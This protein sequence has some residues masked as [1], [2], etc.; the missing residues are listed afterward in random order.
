MIGLFLQVRVGQHTKLFKILKIRTYNEIGQCSKFGGF[1]RK[2]KLDELSQLINVL[3]GDM[4][5]VGPR[6]DIPGFA[7]ILIGEDRV[8]LSVKPGI[9]GPAAL[10]FRNE[11]KLLKEQINP[12]K[13]NL[14]VIW[15]EKVAIN[16]E[17][18]ENYHIFKDVTYMIK[19]VFNVF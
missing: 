7:D 16:K 3:K 18:I 1:L 8:V 15:P 4:S 2:F 5:F 19:T 12:E 14:E 11:E 13:Y 9:T 17:Y 10:R 6:P